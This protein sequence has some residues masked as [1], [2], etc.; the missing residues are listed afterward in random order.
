VIKEFLLAIIGGFL[1]HKLQRYIDRIE[2]RG[3][4]RLASYTVGVLLVFPFVLVFHEQLDDL[5]S[6]KR[7]TV[8]YFGAY[9]PF[10]IG[11]ALG[12]FVDNL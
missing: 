2:E 6:E 5:D 4:N 12:W 11:V 10:G 9:L 8:S 3:W 7:L 1:S